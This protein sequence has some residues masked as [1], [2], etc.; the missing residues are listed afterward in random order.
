M[1]KFPARG[2]QNFMHKNFTCIGQKHVK[3]VRQLTKICKIFARSTQVAVTAVAHDVFTLT[4][5][6]LLRLQ[7]T[8]D[9]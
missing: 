3:K 2:S 6:L 9:T 8:N 4:H 5:T 1:Q 7:A